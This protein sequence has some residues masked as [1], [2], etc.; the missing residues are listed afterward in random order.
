MGM[1]AN[2]RIEQW[3]KMTQSDPDNDMGWFSLGNAYRDA[4]R[5]EEAARALN[6]AIELNARSSRAYQLLGQV[7]IQLNRNDDAAELLTKG[8]V[9]AASQGDVMPQRAMGS[10]LQKLGRPVPE[11]KRTQTAP[12]ELGENVIVDRKS[13]KPGNRLADPPMRGPIGRF[14]YDHYTQDTWREWI[15]MGTKVINELRLDLSREDHSR[16]YE[17]HML[18]WLGFTREDALEH[19]KQSAPTA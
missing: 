12:V 15:G 16:A 8:Y 13:G 3:E 1:D 17:E 4:G 6:R 7:L 2:T 5:S 18:E 10:L 14:I 9:V 19:A 11:V